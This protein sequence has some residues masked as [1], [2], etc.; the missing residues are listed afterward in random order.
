MQTPLLWDPSRDAFKYLPDSRFTSA[1]S[2][3]VVRKYYQAVIVT[4]LGV[5]YRPDLLQALQARIPLPL[6]LGVC[7]RL[8]FYFLKAPA[9][10]G[11]GTPLIVG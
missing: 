6:H 2:A 10:G 9:G 11:L 5:G 8:A 4:I 1:N 3:Q 7:G